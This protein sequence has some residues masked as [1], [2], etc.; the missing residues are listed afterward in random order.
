MALPPSP[1]GPGTGEVIH[2][3]FGISFSLFFFHSFFSERAFFFLFCEER[4]RAITF[5]E[6]GRGETAATMAGGSAFGIW[7]R[8]SNQWHA[9]MNFHQSN[10]YVMCGM[11]RGG[12]HQSIKQQK[13]IRRIGKESCALRLVGWAGWQLALTTNILRLGIT[14]TYYCYHRLLACLLVGWRCDQGIYIL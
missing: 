10:H 6:K 4:R 11:V 5:G 13:T 14:I 2:A 1:C 9:C 12:V 7:I 3:K 8:G